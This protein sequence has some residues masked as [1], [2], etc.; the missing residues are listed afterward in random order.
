MPQNLIVTLLP[1][2]RQ[3][4]TTGVLYMFACGVWGLIM[5]RQKKPMD[6]NYRGLLAIGYVL[7]DVIGLLGMIM[8][9]AGAQPKDS[10]HILYGL[11]AAMSLPAAAVYLQE[12]SNDRKPV[13]YAI[14][15][16]FVFGV[17]IRGIITAG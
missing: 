9:L 15:S 4:A 1:I 12:R 14:V 16:F 7:G 8:L 5:W 3:L 10:V 13:I 2:H 6:A 17:M 11:L